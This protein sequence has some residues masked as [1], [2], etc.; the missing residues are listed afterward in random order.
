[1]LSQAATGGGVL[2]DRFVFS[3]INLVGANGDGLQTTVNL[4]MASG[5]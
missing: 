1:V 4:T 3:A 2:L 5:S